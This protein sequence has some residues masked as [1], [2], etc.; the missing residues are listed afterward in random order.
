MR[1]SSKVLESKVE[2][3][4]QRGTVKECQICKQNFG[5]LNREHKCKRCLKSV[6]SKCG[7]SKKIVPS[8]LNK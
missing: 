7:D 3:A 6:C 2:E 1:N 4:K 5:I 8:F